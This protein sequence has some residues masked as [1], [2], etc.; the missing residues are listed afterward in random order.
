[1][2][3]IENKIIKKT[4]LT[5]AIILILS[6]CTVGPRYVK[7]NAP[8]PEKF[9]QAQAVES[10]KTSDASTQPTTSESALW[11]AFNDPALSAL[12]ARAQQQNKSIEQAAARL[13]ETRALRGLSIF[14]LFPT[15]TAGA[16]AEKSKASNQDPF[17]PSGTGVTEI[18]KAG[19]DA[20]WEI[21]LF[22]GS[23][24]QKKAI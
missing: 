24:Q 8:M 17:I 5:A 4:F 3:R 18:Y 9:E 7:P 23:R 15:I 14:S 20:S 2:T 12:M 6:G 19:F 22:G 21:D 10:G 11:S 1:M 13:R 16:D